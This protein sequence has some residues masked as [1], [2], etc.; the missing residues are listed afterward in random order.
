MG[1]FRWEGEILRRLNHPNIVQLLDAIE[2]HGRRYLIMEFVEGGSLRE[3][4]DGTQRLG[5]RQALSLSIEIADALT[6]AHHLNI[7]HRDI[8][9]ANV[10]LAGD[11][12]PRLA[13]FGVARIEQLGLTRAGTIIGTIGYISPELLQGKSANA[14]SDVWSFGVMLFEML[15]G[16]LPFKEDHSAAGLI[17]SI[18]N[19]PMPDMES[20]RPELPTG[21]IDLVSRMLA[22]E[23]AERIPSFRVVGTELESLLEGQKKRAGVRLT[24]QEPSAVYGQ[25]RFGGQFT[26]ADKAFSGTHHRA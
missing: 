6:R 4:L 2:S 3:K 26:S 24:P 17:R 25:R 7:I 15:T 12:T 20:L 23:P 11:G 10:L 22:K 8:K 16:A 1:R 14:Q 18:L 5:I 19:D 13:D 9:P 21:L